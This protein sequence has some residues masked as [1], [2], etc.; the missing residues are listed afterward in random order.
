MGFV[1]FRNQGCAGAWDF[2]GI[3]A[4]RTKQQYTIRRARQELQA[5][6][7]LIAWQE[8]KTT[9]SPAFALFYGRLFKRQARKSV[10]ACC[11]A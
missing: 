4:L 2:L 11:F 3:T 8:T 5:A 7:S 6:E 9:A 1:H 10:L